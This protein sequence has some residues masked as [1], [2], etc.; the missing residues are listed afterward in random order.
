M[1]DNAHL[2]LSKKQEQEPSISRTF[3]RLNVLNYKR[4]GQG[5]T[6]GRSNS[7]SLVFGQVAW[8]KIIAVKI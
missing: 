4:S 5:V 8:S 2:S 6:A 7:V 3:V 1:Y